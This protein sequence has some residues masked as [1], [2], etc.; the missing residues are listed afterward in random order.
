MEKTVGPMPFDHATRYLTRLI[1]ESGAFHGG[2]KPVIGRLKKS[3]GNKK[4]IGIMSFDHQVRTRID[5]DPFKGYHFNFEN[6]H[7]GEKICVLINDMTKDQYEKYIDTLTK[8]RGPIETPKRP[9]FAYRYITEKELKQDFP[10]E[11]VIVDKVYR[12]LSQ[13]RF[14]RDYYNGLLSLE[15]NLEIDLSV[16]EI[17]SINRKLK[18]LNTKIIRNVLF[19]EYYCNQVGIEL[20]TDDLYESFLSEDSFVDDFKHFRK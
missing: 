20:D 1:S 13:D 11:S 8:G 10:K 4:V 9:N 5:Y 18:T 6:D 12:E 14:V 7:T 2:S 16:D 15:R 19:I 3:S 17:K